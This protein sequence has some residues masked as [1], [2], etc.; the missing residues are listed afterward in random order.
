MDVGSTCLKDANCPASMQ[1]IDS[2]CACMVSWG[3]TGSRCTELTVE[4]GIALTARCFI[5]LAYGEYCTPCATALQPLDVF[6]G[7]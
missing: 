4:A 5:I 7:T 6:P 1:C 3:L 2:A